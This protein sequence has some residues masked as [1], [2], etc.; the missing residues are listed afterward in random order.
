MALYTQ[1]KL[2]L[3]AG[4]T[5]KTMAHGMSQEQV[6]WVTLAYEDSAALRENC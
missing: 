3:S 2:G 5:D 4:R 1:L 6:D